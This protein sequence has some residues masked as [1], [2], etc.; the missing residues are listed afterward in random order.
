M[1][2]RTYILAGAAAATA[3]V[4]TSLWRWAEQGDAAAQAPTST[5]NSMADVWQ[6]SFATIDG[7]AVPLSSFKSKPLLLNFWAT[8]CAPCITEIP[9]LDQFFKNHQ[10][11]GW[12]VLGLALDNSASVRE[13]LARKPVR[14]PVALV[15]LRGIELIRF[16]GN[17]QGGLPFS[18]VLGANGEIA[19]HKLGA[20]KADELEQ[21]SNAH[22]S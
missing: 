7:A 1:N 17:T 11:R 18:V 3:G 5:L 16:L 14:F 12:N 9:L 6:M 10:A 15:G 2:R 21:W 20:V 22:I 8:W 13:F 19:Q 4:G